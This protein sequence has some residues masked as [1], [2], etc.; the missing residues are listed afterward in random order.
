[1]KVRYGS[2]PGFDLS[3]SAALKSRF[4]REDAGGGEGG[5]DGTEGGGSGDG[6]AGDSKTFSQADLDAKVEERLRR[7]RSKYADY[8][9]L[10]SKAS[11]YEEYEE[12]NKDAN[13]KA[14]DEAVKAA[15]AEAEAGFLQTR[16]EDRVR[17]LAAKDFADPED[18]VYRL[19]S[20]TKELLRNGEI[21]DAGI[22][23][24]LDLLLKDKPYLKASSPNDDDADKKKKSPGSVD[25]G[26][27]KT[28]DDEPSSPGE[29]MRKAYAAGK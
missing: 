2:F 23:G 20:K 19:G 5:G 24:E 13:Q 29:R 25:G 26:A 15:K 9:D 28:V 8:D 17:V 14:I 1:M 18:A 21:D 7:E 6:G 27:R 12:K 22:K 16:L 3:E 11:K 10:K 4:L